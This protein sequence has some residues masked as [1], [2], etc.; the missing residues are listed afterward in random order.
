MQPVVVFVRKLGGR[1]LLRREAMQGELR[2]FGLF[3]C[4]AHPLLG[5]R[6]H[7][8]RCRIPGR[9][10]AME[11]GE[12]AVIVPVLVL[13]VVTWSGAGIGPVRGRVAL[14][15]VGVYELTIQRADGVMNECEVEGARHLAEKNE[16]GQDRCSAAQSPGLHHPRADHGF[17]R[18][19][20][21]LASSRVLIV[22]VW[23]RVNP[24]PHEM[25]NEP[26]RS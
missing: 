10:V 5:Q 18:A 13:R 14:A 16:A 22:S 26:V 11:P 20:R 25:E 8:G 19:S 24:R 15:G 2:P 21:S 6:R 17:A 23:R 4:C 12:N 9:G 3:A 7:R 1:R